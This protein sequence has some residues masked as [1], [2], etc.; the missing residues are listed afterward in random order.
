MLEN[1]TLFHFIWYRIQYITL[2]QI[3]NIGYL[4]RKGKNKK[5]D[6]IRVEKYFPIHHEHKLQY[7]DGA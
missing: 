1:N 4:L 2:S 3:F 7:K 6:D 5:K